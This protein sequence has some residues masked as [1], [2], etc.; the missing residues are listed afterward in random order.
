[1][2]K[3]VGLV[4]SWIEVAPPLVIFPQKP[5]ASPS[6]ETI[7]EEDSEFSDDEISDK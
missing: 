1:M 2:A 3:R 5:S 4:G 6:L 7:S